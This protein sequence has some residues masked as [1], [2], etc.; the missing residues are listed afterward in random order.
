M[1]LL[2]LDYGD[3]HIGIAIATTFIAEA[4]E[5]APN[6]AWKQRIKQLIAKHQIDEIVVGIS[7]N[8]MAEKIKQFAAELRDEF[9]L[10]IH[11][12]DETLSSQDT[13]RQMAIH[14]VKKSVREAKTDHF[15]AAA[16]L[17]DYIDSNANI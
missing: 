16:I 5:I 8:V 1:N 10:P 14:G 6:S 17:Q 7:E 9:H 15:V 3:K 13:R 2:G 4:L 12:H 11:F